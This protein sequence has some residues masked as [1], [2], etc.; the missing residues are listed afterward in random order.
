[1]KSKEIYPKYRL[2]S[3]PIRIKQPNYVG[4]IRATVTADT[5]QDARRLISAQYGIPGWRIG[6]VKEVK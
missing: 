1:M 3:A 2:W 5:M 4:L 6:A